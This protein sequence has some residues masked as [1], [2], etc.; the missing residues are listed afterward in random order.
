M[1][2]ENMEH[3]IIVRV[4]KMMVNYPCLKSIYVVVD[5]LVEVPIDLD[6]N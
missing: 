5:Q 3:I 6:N 2:E 1:I 4:S